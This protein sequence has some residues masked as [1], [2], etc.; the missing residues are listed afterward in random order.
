M[1]VTI[2]FGAFA[3]TLFLTFFC[4]FVS[5]S[6]SGSTVAY[7]ATGQITSTDFPSDIA[8]N[9][10]FLIDFVLDNS[11]TDSD[12]RTIAG[13][14]PEALLSFSFHLLPGYSTGSY[15]G[16][17]TIGKGTIATSEYSGIDRFYLGVDGGT[18]PPLG[19]NPFAALLFVLDDPSQTSS[20]NDPGGNP[21]L[22]AVLHG[23][24]DLSQFSDTV[25]RLSSNDKTGMAEGIVTSL[26]VVPE[27]SA[28]FLVALGFA[29]LG[30][31]RA[32]GPSLI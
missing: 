5:T 31:R 2:K 1:N 32:G 20:I 6:V 7:R 29:F 8:L 24:L 11:V 19:G 22:G 17:F 16:G 18:F 12:S 28:I 9:D 30:L 4:V 15:P 10:Q 26:T 25:V 13:M 27:P 14:F 23:D 3:Q 21:S